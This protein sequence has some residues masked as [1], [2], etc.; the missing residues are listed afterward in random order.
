MT[1]L[2]QTPNLKCWVQPKRLECC[3]VRHTCFHELQPSKIIGANAGQ[4]IEQATNTEHTLNISSIIYQ[5]IHH[6]STHGCSMLLTHSVRQLGFLCHLRCSPLSKLYFLDTC[7][8]LRLPVILMSWYPHTGLRLLVV[9]NQVVT[10]GWIQAFWVCTLQSLN[11]KYLQNHISSSAI[12]PMYKGPMPTVQIFVFGRKNQV[13]TT[14]CAYCMV[15]IRGVLRNSGRLL[16][17][18]GD[19]FNSISAEGQWRISETQQQ[20]KD[21][22]TCRTFVTVIVHASAGISL[23]G[24]VLDEM[25]KTV[26]PM[27]ILS[28]LVWNMFWQWSS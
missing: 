28:W 6:L 22:T 10:L 16:L 8:S 24:V 11:F 12:G 7:Q 13:W 17:L 5:D 1:T 2:S 15:N 25:E 26:L 27:R 14:L 21:S 19:L 23:L 4:L 3:C 18:R 20:K 9:L